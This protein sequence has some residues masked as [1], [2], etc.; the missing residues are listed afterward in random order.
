MDQYYYAHDGGEFG[1]FSAAGMR[2][3][4]EAGRILPTDTIWKEGTS[5]RVAAA[6]VKD[7]YASRPQA[8]DPAVAGGPAAS[9]VQASVAKGAAPAA[10]PL[11]PDSGEDLAEAPPAPLPAPEP[12]RPPPDPPKVRKRRVISIKGGVIMSQ[13]GVEVRYRKKC[14]VCGH[15][16]ATRS[17]AKILSG[18][19]RATYFCPSCRK[20]R[21]VEIMGA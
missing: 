14:S 4:A 1:P 20:L 12:R 21:T 8:A 3:E 11:A 10:P 7:L 15:E 18:T 19:A 9:Q 5:A 13:D 16:D 6:K 2:A 17:L